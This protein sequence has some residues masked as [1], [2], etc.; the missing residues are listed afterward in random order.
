M[1]GITFVECHQFLLLVCKMA[2][3]WS[4]FF[5]IKYDCHEF[6]LV[7]NLCKWLPRQFCLVLNLCKFL[8]LELCLAVNACRFLECLVNVYAITKAVSTGYPQL[9]DDP[10]SLDISWEVGKTEIYREN[11]KAGREKRQGKTMW[12]GAE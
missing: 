10:Y 7:L 4:L 12:D 3:T 8:P 2:A 11:S 6:Q 1:L 9:E 5:G